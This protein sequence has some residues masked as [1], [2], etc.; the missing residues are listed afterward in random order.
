LNFVNTTSKPSNKLIFL[1]LL[2]MLID[3]ALCTP[4]FCFLPY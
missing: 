4:I 1:S 3:A 2:N